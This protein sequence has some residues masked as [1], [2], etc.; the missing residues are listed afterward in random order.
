[1][2][3]EPTVCRGHVGCRRAVWA[4]APL[5]RCNLMRAVPV[6]PSVVAVCDDMSTYG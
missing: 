3:E 6:L 2:R 4:P 1:M 5:V